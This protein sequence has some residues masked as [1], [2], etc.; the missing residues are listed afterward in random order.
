[1]LVTFGAY[2]V[3]EDQEVSVFCVV[4]VDSLRFLK[5]YHS[6]NDLISVCSFKLAANA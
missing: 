4:V 3:K 1:M 2:R 6:L 5:I